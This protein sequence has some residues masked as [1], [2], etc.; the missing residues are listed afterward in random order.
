[1]PLGPYVCDFMCREAKLVVELDDGQ[2]DEREELDRRRT[3]W[4][5]LEG[6][7]VI[8]FWNNEVLGNAEGVLLKIANALNDRPPPAPPASGR[9]VA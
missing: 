6:Y 7:R 9:G 1:M 5:G 8:R 2:H 3:E 4:I